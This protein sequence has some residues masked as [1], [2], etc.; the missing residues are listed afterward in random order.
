VV[1]TAIAP[2][3]AVPA[4]REA[5]WSIDRDL[6][7]AQVRTMDDIMSEAAAHPRFRTFIL[8]SFGILGLVLAVVGVYGVMSY[9]VSQRGHELGVR[10]ALGAR[11]VDLVMLVLRDAA[12][13]AGIGVAV[14][15]AGALAVTTLTEKMLFGVTSKDPVTFV[16]VTVVLSS[17][18]LLASWVPAR[19]AARV[20]PLSV[21]RDM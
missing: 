2:Q 19:R 11:P 1:R 12:L 15:I 6:P 10:A 18:A 3:S 5:V 17:A 4:V 21:I 13:L 7:L 14:G 9:A 16:A 20:D 8:S